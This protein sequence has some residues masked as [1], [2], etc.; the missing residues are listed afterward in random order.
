MIEP[1]PEKKK[2]AGLKA[3]AIITITATAITATAVILY[4]LSDQALAVLAGAVCGV[5]AALPTAIIIAWFTR[6]IQPDSS[7]PTQPAIYTNPVLIPPQLLQPPQ[8]PAQP[9]IFDVPTPRTFT[10]VGGDDD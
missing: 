5:S 4:R 1:T 9:S 7:P 3:T 10:I 8:P 6:R 2:Y